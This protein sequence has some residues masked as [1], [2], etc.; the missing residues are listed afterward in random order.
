MTIPERAMAAWHLADI[1]PSRTSQE[2]EET[3][4]KQKRKVQIT[5]L[6]PSV[7]FRCPM[8]AF[9]YFK[10]LIHFWSYSAH[11]YTVTKPRTWSTWWSSPDENW[12]SSHRDIHLTIQMFISLVTME[13]AS[14]LACYSTIAADHDY[15]LL[16]D[17]LLYQ[18]C[19]LICLLIA[20]LSSW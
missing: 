15:T 8:P 14:L 3:K 4:E 6:A 18:A 9:Q 16:A 13:P 20:L 7:K 10:Y 19:W 5:F 1:T 2:A 11:D 17:S 12:L